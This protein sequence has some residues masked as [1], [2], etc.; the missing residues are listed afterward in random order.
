MSWTTTSIELNDNQTQIRGSDINGLS[1][2]GGHT[3]INLSQFDTKTVL[4]TTMFS[5]YFSDPLLMEG[6]LHYI[7]LSGLS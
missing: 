3:Y 6:F 5:F 2:R 1:V 4:I 7:T